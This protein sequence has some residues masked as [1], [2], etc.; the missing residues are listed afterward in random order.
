MAISVLVIHSSTLYFQSRNG[1][2]Y[3]QC[4]LSFSS[5]PFFTQS[6]F[7]LSVFSFINPDLIHSLYSA[8]NPLFHLFFYIFQPRQCHFFYINVMGLTCPSPVLPIPFSSTHPLF[9]YLA[10]KFISTPESGVCV[11]PF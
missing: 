10:I 4:S 6:T 11:F 7:C 5:F 1:H 8:D 9:L 3:I 2:F